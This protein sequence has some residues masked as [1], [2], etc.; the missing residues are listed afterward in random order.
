MGYK[1][2]CF[3]L[4]F[5][6]LFREKNYTAASCIFSLKI[7]KLVQLRGNRQIVK[8]CNFLCEQLPLCLI[9]FFLSFFSHRSANSC[10]FPTFYTCFIQRFHCDHI[11][12]YFLDSNT[13]LLSYNIRIYPQ[14]L[15]IKI[16][17]GDETE[18]REK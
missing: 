16:C 11:L 8:S 6:M 10:I 14:Y 1:Y 17:R 18:K 4:G 15:I 7:V 2:C 13:T 12:V 3:R 5:V 9:F